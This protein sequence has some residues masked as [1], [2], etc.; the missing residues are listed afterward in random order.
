MNAPLE[1]FQDKV[2]N[3]ISE[4]AMTEPFPFNLTGGTALIRFHSDVIYRISYDLDFFSTDSIYRFDFSR[5]EKF[6]KNRFVLESIDNLMEQG[7][8][9]FR[10]N[11][12][13]EDTLLKVEF[14]EDLFAGAFE[15]EPLEG[16][17]FKIE[18]IYAIYTRKIWAVAS[19]LENK[20]ESWN[21]I[22][23]IIDLMHLDKNYMRFEKFFTQKFKVI[24]KQNGIGLSE[25]R[26][27][28]YLYALMEIILKNYIHFEKLLEEQYI[29]I[30]KLGDIIKWLEK[31]E[32]A[33]RHGQT[34]D[35]LR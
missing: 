26:M 16:Y 22:K 11:I 23:D 8:P 3:A 31:K 20:R 2:L 6:L 32:K 34:P 13:D 28:T 35:L 17:S 15:G 19:A 5:L 21:R 29:S 27:L 18:P 30:Y 25:G 1:S 14:V 24:A 7:T 10:F 33:L 4:Y 9:F 12:V